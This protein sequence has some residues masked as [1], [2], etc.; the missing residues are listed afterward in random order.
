MRSLAR[1]FDPMM[2]DAS[3]QSLSL[4]DVGAVTCREPPAPDSRSHDDGMLAV[5]Q[6]LWRW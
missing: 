5:A 2:A 1:C 3:R 6:P 4:R